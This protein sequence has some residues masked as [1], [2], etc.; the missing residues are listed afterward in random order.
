MQDIIY[1]GRMIMKKLVLSATVLLLALCIFG[2]QKMPD[3]SDSQAF[4]ESKPQ[5]ITS[6]E[7]TEEDP[8]KTIKEKLEQKLSELEVLEI[9]YAVNIELRD[10]LNSQLIQREIECELNKESRNVLEEQLNDPGIDAEMLET[11]QKKILES[12]AELEE[13]IKAIESLKGRIVEI[14]A[15]LELD[16]KEIETIKKEIETIKKELS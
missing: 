11:I 4:E 15:E 8:D 3:N 13:Q 12:N 7:N 16:K 2:C 10:T 6:S 9:N 5:S 1:G 14:D